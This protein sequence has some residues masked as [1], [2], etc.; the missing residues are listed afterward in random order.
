MQILKELSVFNNIKYYDEPHT[1]YIDGVKS[2][3]CTGLIH[4]FG[5]EFEDGI[6]KPDRWAEKQGHIYKA[7]S[8]ADRY[9]HKQNFYPK[10][11]DKYGRPDYSNP[12]P[13]NEW[14]T[15][16]QIKSEWRYKNI[17]ATYEGSTLHDYIENYISNKIKP[18][19]K[20]SPEGLLFEEIE[21]TYNVMKGYFHNFYND[22]IAQ[23]K[24]IPVKSELVVGDEELLLCGMIDQIFWSVKHQC[25][26]IWDWK[27]NTLLKMFNEFGNKMKYCLSELDE[28]EF[29]TYSLQLNVYK[30]IIEKN[31]NLRFGGCYLVWYNEENP[32]YEII[33][34]EDYSNYVDEMFHMLRTQKELFF[35]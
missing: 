31:T 33:K 9:A 30:K 18:E 21:S 1:Y 32:N 14:V 15:E 25:L 26:Q 11:S 29:N 22:T 20:I 10:E 19:P 23:G 17:H 3:S 5:H 27:T 6:L 34:C 7:N 8:M 12:K 16:E 24:L 28:C 2:I 4:K 35:S 13:I